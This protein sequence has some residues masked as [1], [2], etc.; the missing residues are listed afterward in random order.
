MLILM[1]ILRECMVTKSPLIQHRSKVEL[2]MS[3]L[4]LIVSFC[5]SWSFK[6]KLCCPLWRQKLLLWLAVAVSYFLSWIS[7]ANLILQL[8]YLLNEQ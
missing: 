7:F 4:L 2:A 6:R 5:G 1:L 8:Y 3:S